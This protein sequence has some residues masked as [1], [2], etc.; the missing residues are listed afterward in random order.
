MTVSTMTL[1]VMILNI[2]THSAA[3]HYL[4]LTLS[5]SLRKINRITILG[6]TPLGIVTGTFTFRLF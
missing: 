6:I 5:L 4:S 1:S 2:I 3:T